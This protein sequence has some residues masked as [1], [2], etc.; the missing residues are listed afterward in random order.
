MLE[1][2]GAAS[3]DGGINLHGR[4]LGQ[5]LHYAYPHECP[6][7][8]LAGTSTP[9]T[10]KEYKMNVPNNLIEQAKVV[11]ST[12]EDMTL[13]P[14]AEEQMIITGDINSFPTMEDTVDG[15]SSSYPKNVPRKPSA[16]SMTEEL[17]TVS[18]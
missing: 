2:V 10:V 6:Y 18:P 12:A 4:L 5:W 16:W 3:D 13:D 15:A 11:A 7:P 9:Q 17:E 14:E 1:E 8:Q